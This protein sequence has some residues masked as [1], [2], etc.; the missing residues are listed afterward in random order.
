[1]SS[2][3]DILE[4]FL[5]EATRHQK[6]FHNEVPRESASLGFNRREVDLTKFKAAAQASNQARRDLTPGQ[7]RLI[8]AEAASGRGCRELAR[9]YGCNPGT[10]SRIK[11][12]LVYKDV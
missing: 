7:V 8:R 12:G 4:V 2:Q 5:E 11:R 1:M 9:K 6:V 3:A 10:V